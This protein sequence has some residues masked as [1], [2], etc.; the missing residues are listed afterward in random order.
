MRELKGFE[1]VSLAPGGSKTVRFAITPENCAFLT[2]L[3][4][5]LW[6]LEHLRLW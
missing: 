6:N 2:D 3:W 1:R 5:G 4:T